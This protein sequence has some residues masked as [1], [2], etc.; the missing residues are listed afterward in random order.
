M[1]E[2]VGAGLICLVTALLAAATRLLAAA[3]RRSHR[4]WERA[5]PDYNPGLHAQEEAIRLRDR[6]VRARR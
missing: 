3:V 5:Y 6:H 1:T 4:E 2:V